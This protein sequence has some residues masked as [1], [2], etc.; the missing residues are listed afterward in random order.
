[1]HYL[2]R[3]RASSGSTARN[4]STRQIR[5]A[6][7]RH[8]T[9]QM[10]AATRHA[11][12]GPEL[13]AISDVERP[14]PGPGEV[15]VRVKAT[16]V[17]AGDAIL[18]RGKPYLARLVFGISKPSNPILGVD[19][20]GVVEEVHPSVTSFKPG[21]QVFGDVMGGAAAEFVCV[22]ADHL[23]LKPAKLSFV[24]AAALPVGGCTALQG[25]RDGGKL[26]PGQHALIIGASG[27]VGCLAVQIAHSMGAKVTAVCS[28]A[29][30]AW[31]KDLGAD[32]VIDYTKEDFTSGNIT[33]DVILDMVGDHYVSELRK[34]L[35]PNGAFVN[36]AGDV[37]DWLGPLPRIFGILGSSLFTSQR[38]VPLA[39]FTK[40]SDLLELQKLVD[41]GKLRP[42]IE[43]VYPFE[44]I[45]DAYRAK[46]AGHN[47]GRIV[48]EL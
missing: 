22:K 34:V 2:A 16:T 30:T 29:N 46:I 42:V 43:R 31:V 44:E 40:S 37:G 6:L 21:D 12:G 7:R 33:Y 3:F 15:L 11:Y 4:P 32:S 48:V 24:Q 9:T 35:A 28:G 8:P 18:L 26:Q 23:A 47:K 41:D 20:A 13:I 10:R 27:G 39:A 17:A 25:L 14:V 19:L 1:M 5:L 36:G 45:A 38:L